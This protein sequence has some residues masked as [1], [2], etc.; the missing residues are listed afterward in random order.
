MSDI[1]D[2]DSDD[3]LITSVT[4]SSKLINKFF[5]ESLISIEGSNILDVHWV[6]QVQVSG[7]HQDQNSG[8]NGA[9]D[10]VESSV[11]NREREQQRLKRILCANEF[12]E[13]ISAHISF[14]NDDS[15]RMLR[16]NH[17]DSHRMLRS[18]RDSLGTYVERRHDTFFLFLQMFTLS[19][20]GK[21]MI[22]KKCISEQHLNGIEREIYY[23]IDHELQ[24]PLKKKR[25]FDFINQDI[26][27]KRLISYFVVSYVIQYPVCYYLDKTSYP[28]TRIGVYNQRNQPDILQRI[29]SDGQERNSGQENIV[30]INVCQEYRNGL[31]RNGRRNKSAPYQRGSIVERNDELHYALYQLNFFIWFDEISGQ[32]VFYDFLED[33]K[34]KKELHE[35]KKREQNKEAKEKGFKLKK[36][37]I[38]LQDTNGENY[39]SFVGRAILNKPLLL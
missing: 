12:I 10:S 24:N 15:R 1:Y 34:Q 14:D 32:D 29:I 38:K 20:Y 3:N 35:K 19:I 31:K 30:W 39:V 2:D 7:A 6:P 9:S 8:F 37:K 4:F 18:N 22:K 17:D 26:A 5:K 27:S 25:I 21:R 36:Q 23:R 11:K 28:Y 33:I 16:S 13:K